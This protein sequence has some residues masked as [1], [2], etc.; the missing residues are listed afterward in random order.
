L[1]EIRAGDLTYEIFLE[2]INKTDWN[3]RQLVSSLAPLEV[4]CA[5]ASADAF[6][7]LLLTGLERKLSGEQKFYKVEQAR[8]REKFKKRR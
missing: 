8:I 1:K 7:V 2:I 3:L 5:S 6:G 4:R